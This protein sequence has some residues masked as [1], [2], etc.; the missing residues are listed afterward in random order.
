MKYFMMFYS[1]QHMY[2]QHVCTTVGVCPP[3]PLAMCACLPWQRAH[4]PW[5][6]DGLQMIRGLATDGCGW[7]EVIMT[8]VFRYS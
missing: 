2:L 5:Q 4:L 8:V 3:S 7:G 1:L 6:R